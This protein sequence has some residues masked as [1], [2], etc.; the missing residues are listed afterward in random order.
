[1]GSGS[2]KEESEVKPVTSAD[3]GKK[4]YLSE[5]IPRFKNELIKVFLSFFLNKINL[6]KHFNPP[7]SLF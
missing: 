5:A 1:M 6:L 2:S 4:D 7:L 3:A